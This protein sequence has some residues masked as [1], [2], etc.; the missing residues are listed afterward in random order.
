MKVSNLKDTPG[1][2]LLCQYCGG[3]YSANPADYF[4][5]KGD[6]IL[7]CCEMPLILVRKTTTYKKVR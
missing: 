1:T 7:T 2:L 4:Q 5:H 6:D 3:E